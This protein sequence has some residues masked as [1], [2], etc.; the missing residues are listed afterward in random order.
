MRTA[1]SEIARQQTKSGSFA[2]M[3]DLCALLTPGAENVLKTA[4]TVH[5]PLSTKLW[6]RSILC[7]ARTL[8]WNRQNTTRSMVFCGILW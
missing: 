7:S 2:E 4:S 5:N 3:L 8:L 1:T 6:L